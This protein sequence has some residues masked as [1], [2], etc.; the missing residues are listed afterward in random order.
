MG[1]VDCVRYCEWDGCALFL[2]DGGIGGCRSVRGDKEADDGVDMVH[3][4][5]IVK[6]TDRDE[7]R[8]RLCEILMRSWGYYD[9]IE[10]F[11]R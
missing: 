8:L 1:G 7:G 2:N 9:V 11:G 6:Y 3:G 4:P 10:L 5:C